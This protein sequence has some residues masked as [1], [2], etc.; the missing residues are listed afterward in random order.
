MPEATETQGQ[1]R[2][3]S[4]LFSSASDDWATPAW[5]FRELEHIYGPF[6]LDPAATKENA[7]APR[8]YTKEEDG[9][10]RERFG[11]V[12]LN[13]PYGKKLGDWV[14][15]AAASVHRQA[16]RVV[17]LLPASTDAAWWHDVVL[18]EGAAVRWIRGRLAFGE[19]DQRAPFAS[20]VVVFTKPK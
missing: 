3:Q 7:K 8:F 1:Y 12:W 10:S 2:K 13:P 9:L 16:D 18:A 11:R 4:A 19:K 15:K 17:C 20:V 5:L 14:R 6:D